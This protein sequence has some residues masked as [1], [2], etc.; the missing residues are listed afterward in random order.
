MFGF[1]SKTISEPAPD[2]AYSVELDS[3]PSNAHS[4]SSS[5]FMESSA[6]SP[7]EDAELQV[8]NIAY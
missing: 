4:T 8:W 5:N 2:P 1:G 6:A 7:S 3:G